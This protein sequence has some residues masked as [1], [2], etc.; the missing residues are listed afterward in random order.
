MLY[1]YIYIYLRIYFV[2]YTRLKY[3]ARDVITGRRVFFERGAGKGDRVGCTVRRDHPHPVEEHLGENVPRNAPRAR[4]EDDR[5]A[6][7]ETE[8]EKE[9]ASAQGRR[10]GW[11]GEVAADATSRLQK[12]RQLHP[13]MRPAYRPS[14]CVTC[15]D[16][17]A[18]APPV[19]AG[20]LD[21]RVDTASRSSPPPP[22]SPPSRL[23]SFLRFSDFR[24]VVNIGRQESTTVIGIL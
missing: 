4:N 7:E 20:N 11:E 15:C 9:Q 8:G 1:I 3:S 23:S 14:S 18:D 24:P 19:R 12:K 5:G 21:T 22:R 16:S 17:M 13:A 10:T 6:D 2:Y